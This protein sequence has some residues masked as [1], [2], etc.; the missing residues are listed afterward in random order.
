MISQNSKNMN[1]DDVI[2]EEEPTKTRQIFNKYQNQGYQGLD[3]QGLNDVQIINKLHTHWNKECFTIQKF[4][5][6]FKHDHA[7]RFAYI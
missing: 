2:H 7:Q 5:K 6:A 1:N 3:F 4:F